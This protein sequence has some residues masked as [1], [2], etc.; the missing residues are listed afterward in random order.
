MCAMGFPCRAVPDSI[1]K[2]QNVTDS[3]K[4]GI[5]QYKNGML[6]IRIATL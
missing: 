1:L 5:K 3:E 2:V 6:K 4:V